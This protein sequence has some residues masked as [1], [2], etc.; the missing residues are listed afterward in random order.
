[1]KIRTMFWLAVIGGAYYV[2]CRRGGTLSY[3]SIMQSLRD[4]A[5]S[6][7]NLAPKVTGQQP[8][9]SRNMGRGDYTA[10]H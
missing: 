5:N 8:D 9:V 4:L 10:P 6:V 7:Q 1:M 2:H 3:D